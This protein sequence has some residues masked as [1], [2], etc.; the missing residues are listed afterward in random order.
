MDR[1]PEGPGPNPALRL[2]TG[3]PS[4]LDE[5]FAKV[6]EAE[7]PPE[8]HVGDARRDGRGEVGLLVGRG[9][10]KLAPATGFRYLPQEISKRAT[11]PYSR[12]LWSAA[13]TPRRQ[14][15][16]GFLLSGA[17]RAGAAQG[18][19]SLPGALLDLPGEG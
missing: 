2:V 13:N 16:G 5:R 15:S 19:L 8:R 7:R 10:L 17:L 18:R 14:K 11:H 1:W 6:L 12:L 4:N 9:R 3:R